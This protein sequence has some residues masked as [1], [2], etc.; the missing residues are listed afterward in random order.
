MIIIPLF[1]IHI[2]L[3]MPDIP[4]I[5]SIT[6]ISNDVLSNMNIYLYS[7]NT[8]H[9]N[10]VCKDHIFLYFVLFPYMSHHQCLKLILSERISIWRNKEQF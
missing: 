2:H 6:V 10:S 5:L 1:R 7:H 9:Y 8:L 4:L 3:I